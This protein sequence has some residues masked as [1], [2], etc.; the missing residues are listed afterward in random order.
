MKRSEWDVMTR[1]LFASSV[2]FVIERAMPQVDRSRF[3]QVEFHLR[4]RLIFHPLR[5]LILPRAPQVEFAKLTGRAESGKVLP[6][7]QPF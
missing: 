2:D 5:W 1:K 3:S 7:R 6:R 4:R